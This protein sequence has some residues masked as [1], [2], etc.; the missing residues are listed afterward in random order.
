M[1]QI[2]QLLQSNPPSAPIVLA[3]V[4]EPRAEGEELH[5]AGKHGE[6]ARALGEGLDPLRASE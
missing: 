1:A 4:K 3:K 6:S 2:D 5:K